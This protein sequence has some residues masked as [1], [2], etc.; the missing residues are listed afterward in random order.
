MIDVL[1]AVL[2]VSCITWTVT[3]EEIF[4]EVRIWLEQ[5]SADGSWWIRKAAYLPTCHYCFSHWVAIGLLVLWQLPWWWLFPIVWL[6]NHSITLYGW[7]RQ[8]QRRCSLDA[9][10]REIRC[11]RLIS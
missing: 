7:L 8:L 5:K 11:Q 2:T 1:F 6:A 3:Q 9:K 4:K 10:E